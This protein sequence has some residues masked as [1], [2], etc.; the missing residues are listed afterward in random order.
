[1]TKY[2]T[3]NNNDKE[4]IDNMKTPKNRK[5]VFN[6]FSMFWGVRNFLITMLICAIFLSF[7]EIFVFTRS[8]FV[9]FSH[10]SVFGD[11]FSCCV[12]VS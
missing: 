1:M 6:L 9:I 5:N 12:F 2:R 4:K 3:Q 7:F 10:V 11:F 8:V